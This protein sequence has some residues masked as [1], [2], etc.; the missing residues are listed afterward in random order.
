MK[1]SNNSD[2][3]QLHTLVRRPPPP[4]HLQERLEHFRL[5]RGDTAVG[6]GNADQ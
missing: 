4:E 6:P 3:L 2:Q 1:L 5:F